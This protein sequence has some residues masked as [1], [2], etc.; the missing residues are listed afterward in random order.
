MY[1]I[2]LYND[3]RW[4]GNRI[5]VRLWYGTAE[6]EGYMPFEHDVKKRISVSEH[7]QILPGSVYTNNLSL[8]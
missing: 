5:K 6:M 7:K 3:Q 2:V 1:C 8:I 4:A